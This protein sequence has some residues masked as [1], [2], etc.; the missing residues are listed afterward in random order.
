[1]DNRT[2]IVLKYQNKQEDGFLLILQDYSNIACIEDVS[3]DG[4]GKNV[5]KVIGGQY[6]VA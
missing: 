3:Y 5:N 4:I 6:A 1:M 2:A